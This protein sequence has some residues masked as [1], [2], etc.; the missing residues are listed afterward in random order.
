[1]GAE[2]PIVLFLEGSRM[3][4]TVYVCKRRTMTLE[5][6]KEAKE[7]WWRAMKFAI[8]SSRSL[9]KGHYFRPLL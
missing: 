4:R 8:G 9:F 7:P 2:K 3:D 5:K 1:M 6:E